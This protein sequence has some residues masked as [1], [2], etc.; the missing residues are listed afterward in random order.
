MQ[1][2]CLAGICANSVQG[3]G[4]PWRPAGAGLLSL[5]RP[6]KRLPSATQ[7]TPAGILAHGGETARHPANQ[8]TPG[9]A[10]GVLTR[11]N[12]GRRFRLESGIPGGFSPDFRPAPHR[13]RVYKAI[14]CGRSFWGG[15][16]VRH[17]HRGGWERT[18]RPYAFFSKDPHTAR[19]HR[20]GRQKR[21]SQVRSG[22]ARAA[23]AERTE[24]P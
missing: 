17:R 18:Q 5:V 12:I 11:D 19:F 21:P 7:R 24:F 14:R 15:V 13:A 20:S 1:P 10:S 3:F 9:A 23:L 16:R 6:A 22:A 4:R 2:E 8:G